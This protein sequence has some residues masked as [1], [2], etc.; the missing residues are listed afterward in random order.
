MEEWTTRPICHS[1][2]TILPPALCTAAVTGFQASTC[3]LV[4]RPGAKGQPS[5]C[6]LMPVASLMI[7]PA[8]ARWA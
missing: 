3:S 5:P 2:A 4:H 1:W 7:S 8:L 6:R